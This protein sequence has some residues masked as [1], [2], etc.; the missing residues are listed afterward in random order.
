[1]ILMYHHV[2][3]AAEVPVDREQRSMEGWSYNLEP[4]QFD[5]HLHYLASLGYRFVSLEDYVAAIK[6]EGR[7]PDRCVV[8]TFDDGWLDN[9]VYALPILRAHSIPA[10]FFIVSGEM[11]KVTDGRRMTSP[12]LMDLVGHGMSIGAHTR[13]HCD[14]TA[15][16]PAEA[17]TE[18]KECRVTLETLLQR[19]VLHLAYPGGRF[20]RTLAA[21]VKAAGFEAACS[22]LGGG[23]ND[24]DSL[25]WLHRDIFSPGGKSL[26]DRLLLQPL[27]RH[28][29]RWKAL[30]RMP[31]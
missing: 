4:G 23:Q 26:R 16:S 10:T 11:R 9:H 25:F 28:L 8:I 22:S 5:R 14:L 18:L 19:P 30:R 12:Q 6:A 24:L 2:C 27:G 13:T 29:L 21:L 20:N 31:A 7:N 15:L 3:P 1:M 17:T